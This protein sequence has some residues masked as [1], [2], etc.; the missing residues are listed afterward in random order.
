MKLVRPEEL[1]ALPEIKELTPEE[2]AEVLRLAKAAF[3][4][5]DLQKF[6]ELEEGT[7]MEELLAELEQSQKE[8]EK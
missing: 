7:D 1:T 6:T 2:E 8:M 4:A 5:E 3:T